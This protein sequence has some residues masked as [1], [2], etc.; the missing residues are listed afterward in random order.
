M[1][2]ASTSIPFR[3]LDALHIALALSSE[4]GFIVTFDARM[5]EAAELHGL[6]IVKL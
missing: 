1:A 6:K 3:T 4:A 5:S 2:T